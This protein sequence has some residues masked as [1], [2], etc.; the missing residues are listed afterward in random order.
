MGGAGDVLLEVDGHA[1]ADDGTIAVGEVPP[2]PR[3]GRDCRG[4]VGDAAV[5][6]RG[7]SRSG[8]RRHT[9]THTHTYLTR[10]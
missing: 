2:T 6:H 8:W 4:I 5:C 7:C 10:V 3:R 1:V 9:H